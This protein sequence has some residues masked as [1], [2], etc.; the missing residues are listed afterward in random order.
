MNDG[1]TYVEVSASQGKLFEF[2]FSM[3][4]YVLC[5]GSLIFNVRSL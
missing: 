2:F 5:I 3:Y 4:G 1:A